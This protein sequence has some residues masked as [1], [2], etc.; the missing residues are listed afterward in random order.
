MSH[1]V[2][3]PRAPQAPRAPPA[4]A[5]PARA[6]S[7]APSVPTF[8][9]MAGAAGADARAGAVVLV[10]RVLVWWCC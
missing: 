8:Q 7:R 2:P 3:A 9:Q 1:I 5:P 6:P 10:L 4:R